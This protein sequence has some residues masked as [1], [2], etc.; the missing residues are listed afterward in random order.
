MI[1]GTIFSQRITPYPFAY[2]NVTNLKTP[3]PIASIPIPF[4]R[5]PVPFTRTSIAFA[6][7]S[8][9]F[10]WTPLPRRLTWHYGLI[11]L[12]SIDIVFYSMLW[13]LG[14]CTPLE[15]L[16]LLVGREKGLCGRHVRRFRPEHPKCEV[17][18]QYAYRYD[19]DNED[20]VSVRWRLSGEGRTEPEG[21]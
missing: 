18:D 19:K 10:A 16:L 5:T 2:S 8:I 7:T 6:G 14:W 15:T 11:C 21:D 12:T 4:T 9:S 3:N 17:V 20:L 13:R 1:F